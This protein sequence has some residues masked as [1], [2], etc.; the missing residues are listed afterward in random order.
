MKVSAHLQPQ[1]V[2]FLSNNWWNE[3][4]IIERCL[5][6]FF[7]N[8]LQSIQEL[9]LTTGC[10]SY[11]LLKF[12]LIEVWLKTVKKNLWITVW[13][14]RAILMHNSKVTFCSWSYR[15]IYFNLSL[16]GII[17]SRHATRD[18]NRGGESEGS[19]QKESVALMKISRTAGL[20]KP[21]RNV[22]FF[23]QFC[24]HLYVSL[25]LCLSLFTVCVHCVWVCMCACVPAKRGVDWASHLKSR[26]LERHSVRC[27][28]RPCLVTKGMN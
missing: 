13:D 2:L 22:C 20:G 14:T 9:Q 17:V 12:L 7:K 26:F 27:V 4:T 28:Q 21:A 25:L 16:S 3:V 24:A 6:P 18:V 10:I 15:Y 11:S 23:I 19:E 1:D 5:E 8:I